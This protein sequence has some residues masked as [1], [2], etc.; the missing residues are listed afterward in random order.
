MS[1]TPNL[2][3]DL[4]DLLTDLEAGKYRSDERR[5]RAAIHGLDELVKRA[6]FALEHTPAGTPGHGARE[7]VHMIAV[8]LF[9][10]IR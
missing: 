1:K 3:T 2:P 7:I 5:L 8:R 6:A 9:K 4:E 10:A